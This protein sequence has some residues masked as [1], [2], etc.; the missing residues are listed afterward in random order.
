MFMSSLAKATGI[1]HWACQSRSCQKISLWMVYSYSITVPSFTFGTVNS[2]WAFS[3]SNLVVTMSLFFKD[4]FTT[5]LPSRLKA[6]ALM[7][8]TS[9][10]PLVPKTS[11]VIETPSPSK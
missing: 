6:V 1:S 9:S 3:L 11:S 4:V 10:S 5:L 7:L 2:T 8:S